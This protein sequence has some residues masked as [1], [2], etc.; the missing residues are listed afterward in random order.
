M[1]KKPAKTEMIR[2]RCDQRLMME[3]QQVAL[4][5]QL[6]MADIVRMACANFIQQIKNH[7]AANI[8]GNA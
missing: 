3:I 1:M 4:L 8:S 6:D 5:K 2:A 7:N